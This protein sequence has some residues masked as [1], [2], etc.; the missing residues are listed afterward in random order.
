MMNDFE[1]RLEIT[2]IGLEVLGQMIDELDAK[3]ARFQSEI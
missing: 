2:G 3:L 1:R